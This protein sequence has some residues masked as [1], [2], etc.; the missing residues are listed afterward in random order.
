MVA[1]V[2]VASNDAQGGVKRLPWY[3]GVQ[4]TLWEF[5][6]ARTDSLAQMKHDG[7]FICPQA[8]FEK[9]KVSGAG[10]WRSG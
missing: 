6:H 1:Q 2:T 9:I 8:I 7:S 10:W 5:F 3:L 4:A